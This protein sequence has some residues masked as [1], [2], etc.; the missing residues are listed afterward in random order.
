MNVIMKRVKESIW[1][2]AILEK[3]SRQELAAIHG[4][5]LVA[6]SGDGCIL[7]YQGWRDI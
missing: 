2:L 3:M 5:S 1:I 6:L 4:I 7:V